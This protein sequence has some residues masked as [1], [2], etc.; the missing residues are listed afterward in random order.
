[1]AIG[2]DIGSN[3]LRVVKIDCKEMK[4]IA[5]FERV[6]RTAQDIEITSLISQ[7]ALERIVE[8]LQEAKEIIGFDE[9]YKA[10]ATAAFRKA[11]NAREAIAFIYKKTGIEVEVID[12]EQESLYS[13]AGV[14]FGLRSKGLPDKKFL[15]VDIG[16][17]STELVLKHRNDIIFRSFN[18]GILTV[19]QNFKTKEEIIFGIRRYMS[20]IKEFLQDAFELFGKPKIFVGT[21]GTPATVA[22]LKLGLNYENYDASKVSGTT[23]TL[24]DIENAYK[25][26][27][28][29]PL[30]QRA[31]LVGIGRED[32]IIAGLVI[33][34]E[35]MKKAA[36]KEMVVSD[37]GVREGVALE[38]CKQ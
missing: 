14:I 15:M 27:I 29:M 1:M 38:L 8:A 37:E 3:S 11:K 31:K 36:F 6:V 17:G 23:I 13:V 12:P 24:D 22:A 26:L 21:G 20:D 18:F 32:A 34:E 30:Q 16:G 7:A 2:I 5:E 28:L 10:V 33:L 9:P 25:K 19:I 35:I 4:K